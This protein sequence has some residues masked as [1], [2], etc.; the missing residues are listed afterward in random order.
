VW[1]HERFRRSEYLSNWDGELA[2]RALTHCQSF[3]QTLVRQAHPIPEIGLAREH[4]SPAA[5]L[6]TQYTSLA[7]TGL[8]H[9]GV[10]AG[11]SWAW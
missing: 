3:H 9:V 2:T 4:L 11:L 7:V 10:P 8:G 6:T 1:Q 5:S